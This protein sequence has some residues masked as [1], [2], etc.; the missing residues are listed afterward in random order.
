MAFAPFQVAAQN[1][2]IKGATILD[3]TNGDMIKNHVVIV[4]DGRIDA[5]APARS[6]DIPKGVEVID[7]QGPTL[8]P[9]L[10][11]MHVPHLGWWVSRL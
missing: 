8:L 11:D 9:G 10:I 1:I 6:A 2:V 7:L 3:V 5:V 4:R